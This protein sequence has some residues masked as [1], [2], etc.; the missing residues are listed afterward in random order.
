MRFK[1]FRVIVEWDMSLLALRMD[2]PS[3]LGVVLVLFQEW[4]RIIRIHLSKSVVNVSVIAFVC[5][6]HY[7]TKYI[8]AIFFDGPFTLPCT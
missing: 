8:N 4:V 5:H 1:Y 7:V 6:L 2:S 3:N